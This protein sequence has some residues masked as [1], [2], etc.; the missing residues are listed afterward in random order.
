MQILQFPKNTASSC[1]NL[2]LSLKEHRTVTIVQFNR[3]GRTVFRVCNDFST[4]NNVLGLLIHA[5]C[6]TAGCESDIEDKQNP[7]DQQLK[8]YIAYYPLV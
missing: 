8:P 6:S 2:F 1:W 4:F 3:I 7:F 5:I